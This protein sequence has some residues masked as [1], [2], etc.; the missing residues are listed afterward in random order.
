MYVYIKKLYHDTVRVQN[1]NKVKKN[2]KEECKVKFY[3][4]IN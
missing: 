2:Q 4:T 3:K 1:T